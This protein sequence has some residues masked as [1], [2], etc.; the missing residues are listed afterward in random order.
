MKNND[1]IYIACDHAG[2]E[3]K[4]Q[5]FN[6]IKDKYTTEDLGT[7]SKD[8]VDYP[9]FAQ[10]LAKNVL[11]KECKGILICGSG[12]GMSIAANRFAG[13]RAVLAH[14]KDYAKLSR[15][16]NDSNVLVLGARLISFEQAQKILNI[17]LNTD[18]EGGRHQL[19][20]AKIDL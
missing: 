9:D 11:E 7:K 10:K 19:R 3:L 4:E 13:I 12:V 2:F 15:Q 17:W 16:H 8:S 18:F 20:I 1:L 14:N 6:L 5:I